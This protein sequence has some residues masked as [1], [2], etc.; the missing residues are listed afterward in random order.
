MEKLVMLPSN[1]WMALRPLPVSQLQNKPF[2]VKKMPR[3][4]LKPLVP[5]LSKSPF[6][7]SLI[8]PTAKVQY[9][10]WQTLFIPHKAFHSSRV[11]P[12]TA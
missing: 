7:S 12:A 11:I 4:L 1:P 3:Y 10:E 8:V 5:F 9:T 2:S 6:A